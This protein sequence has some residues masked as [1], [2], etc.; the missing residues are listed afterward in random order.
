[1]AKQKQ[2]IISSKARSNSNALIG[3]AIGCLALSILPIALLVPS[4]GIGVLVFDVITLAIAMTLLIQARG[5]SDAS[6][7]KNVASLIMAVFAVI[8]VCI[9]LFIFPAMYHAMRSVAC[10]LETVVDPRKCPSDYKLNSN[11]VLKRK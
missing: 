9:Y 1:M 5:S 10:G 6:R 11:Q 3:L 8:F 7:S 4:I 2:P